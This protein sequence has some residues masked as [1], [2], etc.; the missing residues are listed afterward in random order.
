MTKE[1]I[2]TKVEEPCWVHA[3]DGSTIGEAIIFLQ[4]LDPS[5]EMEL[6]YG[7]EGI[8]RGDLYAKREETDEEYSERLEAE[9][10]AERKCEEYKQLVQERLDERLIMLKSKDAALAGYLEKHRDNPA[11]GDLE[12]LFTAV[13]NLARSGASATVTGPLLECMANLESK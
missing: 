12:N 3:L 4:T 10:E 9:E 1:I 7:Y 5:L 11:I 6:D 8:D 13:V 2:R